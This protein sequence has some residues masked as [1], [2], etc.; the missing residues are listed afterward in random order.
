MK[1]HFVFSYYGNKRN[2]CDEIFDVIQNKLNGIDTIIEPYCGSSA[3]SYYMSQKYPKRFKYI[4]ND[5]N[6]LLIELYNLIKNGTKDEHDKFI[7]DLNESIIDLDK[8]I[9]DDIKKQNSLIGFIITH[10]I[11]TIRPGNYRDSP[12]KKFD[13][14]FD[15]PIVKFLKDED[16]TIS[17]LNGEIIYDTYKNN[18][19][20]LIFLDPPYIIESFNYHGDSDVGIYKRFENEKIDTFSSYI[21]LCL[22]NN[23]IIRLLFKDY[24]RKIYDKKYGSNRKVEHVIISNKI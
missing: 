13:N 7:D 18:D 1:N 11:Y 24:I 2:E 9:Y 6:S 19:K 4:L 23:F 17:N 3:F 20:C 22:G 10:S 12:R 8:S 5:N 21:V 14:F 15:A 16:V